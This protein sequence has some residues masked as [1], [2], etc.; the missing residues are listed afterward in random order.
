MQARHGSLSRAVNFPLPCSLHAKHIVLFLFLFPVFPSPSSL[1]CLRRC[2]LLSTLTKIFSIETDHIQDLGSTFGFM[3]Y[4]SY[5]S[6]P[7]SDQYFQRIKLSHRRS[8]VAISWQA[9]PLC[10]INTVLRCRGCS[11]TFISNTMTWQLHPSV[12]TPTMLPFYQLQTSNSG[13]SYVV[14]WLVMWPSTGE[15]NIWP[16]NVVGNI[17]ENWIPT[18][19]F[20]SCVQWKQQHWA[21]VLTRL[22]SRRTILNDGD[23]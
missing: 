21:Y 6:R 19:P 1:S 5:Q 22:P 20:S 17:V 23:T 15:C 11:H 2:S 7:L 8:S 18:V 10:S 16:C 14:T 3:Q 9:R 4:R 13:Q 12:H